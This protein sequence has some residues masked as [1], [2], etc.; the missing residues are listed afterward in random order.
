MKKAV[1]KEKEI[2]VQNGQIEGI[3][4]SGDGSWRKRGFS[5]LFEVT[6]LI[7]WH[8]G[9]IVDV[10]VKSKYCKACEYREAKSGPFEYNE[11]IET[12]ADKR[13]AWQFVEIQTPWKK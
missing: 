7:G 12:H 1:E 4:F 3:T 13:Q 2:C 11:W 6:S 9:K 8:T 10:E 5:S